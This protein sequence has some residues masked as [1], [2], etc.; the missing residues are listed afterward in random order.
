VNERE[1]LEVDTTAAVGVGRRRIIKRPRLTR[2]LD[3]SSARII[4]LVAPAGYG[5]TTLAQEWLDD[6]RSAWY[7]ASTA[8]ADV[9]ALAV[10]LATT[11]AEI[12][13]GAGDRMRQRLRA[14]DRPEEEARILAEMLAEDLGDWPSDS[15]LVIDDYHL[16]L[17]SSPSEAFVG[18]L[19]HR[20]SLRLVITSRRRPTWATAR[21]RLYGEAHEL[22]RALLAMNDDEAL[23]VLS[24]RRD[25]S[26]LVN[27]AAGWPAVIGLAALTL[28]SEMPANEVP[29]A[30]YDYFA[31]E[32][33]GTDP[34]TRLAICRLSLMPSITD[35]AA[36]HLFGP[37]IARDVLTKSVSGGILQVRPGGQFDLHRLLRTF[38]QERLHGFGPDV[39]EATFKDVGA[40]LLTGHL[41]DDALSLAEGFRKPDFLEDLI[42]KSW[43]SLLDQGRLMTLTRLLELAAE[44]GLRS[45]L[46]DLIDAEIAF[47]QAAYQKAEALAL[48]STRRLSDDHLL[49]RAYTRAGQSA[50]LEGREQDALDHHRR[51]QALARTEADRRES[52][53]GEFVCSIELEGT[54]AL[55]PLNRLEEMGT[56]HAKDAVRLANGR[57]LLATRDGERIDS[58]L[59]SAVHRLTRVD[60]PLVRSSFLHSWSLILTMTGRY[61]EALDASELQLEDAEQFRLAF[62]PPLAHI[63][64]AVAL[65]G[66]RRFREALECLIEAQRDREPADDYVAISAATVQV[67][68]LLAMGDFEEALKVP[69]PSNPASAPANAVAELVAVRALGLACADRGEEALEAAHRAHSLS[70]A[71]EPRL[72]VKFAKVVAA[73]QDGVQEG[74][75][76][77]RDVF[78]DVTQS[79]NV[80]AFVTAYR[81]F[82]PLLLGVAGIGGNDAQLA[83]ILVAA[84]DQKVARTV[85]PERAVPHLS[86]QSALT[87]REKDVLALVSQGLRN[88]EIGERLFISEVT[89]KAHVGKILRKLG[90]RSRTHAAS[91]ARG[92]D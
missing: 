92:D 33:L 40:F 75:D 90:A 37:E 27:Q 42:E 55:E 60:D 28:G 45:G 66:L 13:P 67:G 84:S 5:K 58:E 15:W 12:V 10:G 24:Q 72:L 21:L 63:R 81:G 9:A 44:L 86:Q 46:L 4:L 19:I 23:E 61:R 43:E 2:M 79:A 52:L 1:G 56:D 29:T 85:L 3:E 80:D 47:R 8:S 62:V 82:P 59:L 78:Q 48:E 7:R 36:A 16:G 20:S 54:D 39:V 50:H 83:S 89:V 70:S 25:A 71:A 91:L 51:A 41:W 31:E 38:L 34:G 87:A 88:R 49:V 57:I 64:R 32:L 26:Q 17:E 68:I 74:D 6:K 11:A 18:T 76:L 53:W 35:E 77:I 65:R 14:T 73:L 69:E 22:D 30:L